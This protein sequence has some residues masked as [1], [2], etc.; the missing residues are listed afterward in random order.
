[1]IQEPSH[2]SHI[3]VIIIDDHPLIRAG[4]KQ[5]LH[6]NPSI[7]VIGEATSVAEAKALIPQTMPHIILLDLSFAD[8]S[9]FDVLNWMSQEKLNIPVL[10]ISMYEDSA[11]IKKA[12]QHGAKGYLFKRDSTTHVLHAIQKVVDGKRYTSE[13]AAEQL[14]EDIVNPIVEPLQHIQELFSNR[15]YEVY[16]LLGQ[17]LS[18]KEAAAKLSI[19]P[20]TVESHI[21]RMKSKLNVNSSA[22]LIYSAIR[23]FNDIKK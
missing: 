7:S 2:D 16:Q 17:G 23:N 9:G 1:M 10:V 15:E 21:E 6:A 19:S 11:Y 22:E 5:S 13:S 3:T 8:G 20:N 4:I 12:L 14:L 18:R